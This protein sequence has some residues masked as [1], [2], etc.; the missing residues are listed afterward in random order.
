MKKK[1]IFSL[2]CCLL[3]IFGL[4]GC[5]LG[6]SSKDD[7]KDYNISIKKIDGVDV[8]TY[9]SSGQDQLI[10][11]VT[12]KSGKMIGSGYISV[13]YY[14]ENDKKIT[15]YGTDDTRYNMFENGSEVVYGFELPAENNWDHYI[16]ARTEV[17]ITMDEEYQ[18]DYSHIMAEYVENFTYS[19]EKTNEKVTLILKN[20]G[21][22]EE[23]A[24]RSISVVFYKNNR[25]VYS[26][27]V[28]FWF[29]YV[30]AGQTKTSEFDIPTDYKK[31]KENNEDVLIDFDSIKIFRVVEGI[32]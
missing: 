19:Y 17:E 30:G 9:I 24:P 31:S 29:S 5:G 3:V 16:P 18:E 26:K 22:S 13:S 2:I 8:K 21:S 27:D 23:S 32:S 15:I 6:T 7:S 1:T 11:S 4:T 10:V 14:D 28:S 12:N 25:P 20:N